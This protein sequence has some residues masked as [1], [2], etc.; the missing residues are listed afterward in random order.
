LD[1]QFAPTASLECMAQTGDFATLVLMGPFQQGVRHTAHQYVLRAPM[2]SGSQQERCQAESA[3]S[4][5]ATA[6]K[7]TRNVARVV[8]AQHNLLMS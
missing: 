1:V 2:G 6:L 4:P 3:T 7:Q 8:V 5:V